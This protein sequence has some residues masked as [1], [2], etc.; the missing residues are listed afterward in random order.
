VCDLVIL[1]LLRLAPNEARARQTAERLAIFEAVP[2][3][4]SLWSRAREVQLLLAAQ[5]QHRRA[6]PADL[7]IAATA[8][9]AGVKVI[10]YDHDYERIAKV[11]GLSHRWFVAP[12]S[13]A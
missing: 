2:M 13:L 8:E 10:H 1:E 9:A 11:T 7:M 3:E 4:R 5:G 6:P 12:G